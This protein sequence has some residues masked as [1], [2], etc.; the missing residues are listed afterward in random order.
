VK[1]GDYVFATLAMIAFITVAG[2]V[3]S[4]TKTSDSEKLKREAVAAGHAEFVVDKEGNVTFKWK[5]ICK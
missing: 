2:I 4:A 1:G 5:E 3:V